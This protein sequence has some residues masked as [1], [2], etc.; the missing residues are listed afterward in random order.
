MELTVIK[1]ITT[2]Y[3]FL[4]EQNKYIVY[5]PILNL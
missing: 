5:K 3:F 2:E 4:D 1:Y